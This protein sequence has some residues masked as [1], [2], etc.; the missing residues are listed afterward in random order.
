M[1]AYA[2]KSTEAD[3][4]TATEP[5]AEAEEPVKLP[6]LD[7]LV[8]WVEDSREALA[9]SRKLQIRDRDY[10]DGNQ[11]TRDEIDDLEERKQPVVTINLIKRK[12]D[13]IIGEAIEKRVD[14][15]ARPRTPQHEDSVRAMTDGLRFVE[16]EEDFDAV[17]IA[18]YKDRLTWGYGGGLKGYEDGKHTCIHVDADRLIYDHHSR[19]PDFADAKFKGFDMWMDLDDAIDRWP[20]AE[21]TLRAAVGNSDSS[22]DSDSE[23]T[24]RNWVDRKN[25]R[26]RVTELYFWVGEDCY[27]ACF[28]KS[29]W[30][31]EPK[32]TWLLDEDKEHSVC[33]LELE[34][35]YVDRDGAR[36]GVVRMLI[37]PQDEVNKRTSKYLNAMSVN[38]V[39][40][41]EGAILDVDEFLRQLA[42]PGG[43]SK[44][45][46]G[47]LTDGRVVQ[48]KSID[49]AQGD[50]TLLQEAKNAI[51]MIG[52]S[53]ANLPDLPDSASGRA[54][55]FRQKAASRELAP[56][57]DGQR[58]WRK[59]M[60][61]LSYLCIRQHWTEEKWTRVTDDEEM[62]GYRFVG[63]NQQM[64]R[65]QRFS[66]MLEKGAPPEK[67]LQTAAGEFAPL[68]LRQVQ[69]MAQRMAP[70][71]QPSQPGQPPAQQQPPPLEQLIPQHP[72]MQ[73]MITTNQVDRMLVDI[74]L[75]EAPDTAILADEEFETLS[76]LAPSVLQ[77][78]PQMAPKVTAMLLKA[79]NLRNKKEL[80]ADLEKGPDPQQQQMQQQMQQLQM[81]LQQSQLALTQAQAQV[82]QSQAQ[83]NTARA[84]QANVD[85]QAATP[86]AQADIALKQ[87]QAGATGADVALK[88]A[89]TVKTVAEAQAVPERTAAEIEGR[90]VDNFVKTRPQPIG[91]PNVRTR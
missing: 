40:Y 49:M 2:A 28:T 33:P 59:R 37:S 79:S 24:P 5:A 65:A 7:T 60:Y 1:T 75:D 12:I 53:A 50:L 67:A 51:S 30:L 45:E 27:R 10:Y 76:K 62:T 43:A 23:D 68:I 81:A 84:A 63:F 56:V 74:V 4:A 87:A 42:D 15:A 61:M 26:L 29:S 72:L 21:K 73:E 36:Y 91:V 71:Q 69:Q 41:E 16:E 32:R 11:W 88:Q 44:V 77:A 85:A 47:A 86:K 82:A 35:C 19:S 3:E 46:E 66:E 13:T 22:T 64:T 31:D 58:R 38:G 18:A 9:K 80:V 17:D 89:Q 90:R 54:F 83:L 55:A 25:E 52:P 70:Q 6:E 14:P 20:D 48:R 39:I 8:D 78:A 34:S 57:D